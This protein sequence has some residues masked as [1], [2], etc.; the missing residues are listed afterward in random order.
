MA[1]HGSSLVIAMGCYNLS[2]PG[3]NGLGSSSIKIALWKFEESGVK[4][5]KGDGNRFNLHLGLRSGGHIA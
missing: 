1:T 4:I 5:V 3:V 2:V